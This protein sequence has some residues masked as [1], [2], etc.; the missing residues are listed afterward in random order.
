MVWH[1][2]PKAV[3]LVFP[4][5][6]WSGDGSGNQVFLTFD[7][8]PVPGVTDFVLNELAKRDQKATFFMVGDNLQKHRTLGVEV[9]AAGH[10][11]G[12]HTNNHLNGW[13]TADHEYLQN[14]QGFDQQLETS[15]GIQTDLFRPPYGRIRRSQANAVLKSKKLVMWN[16][17][18]GDFDPRIDPSRI[19]SKSIKN[20]RPGSIVLFHD[21]KKTIKTIRKVLPEY[22]DFLKENGLQT[23]L[24]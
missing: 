15:L 7:D 5:R 18:S 6:I 17:L 10:G 20:T 9:L 3:Q 4:R 1:T 8:G 13:K 22:L 11:V 14:I 16:V 21:Q 23:G 2:V 19:L 12:N 24:L